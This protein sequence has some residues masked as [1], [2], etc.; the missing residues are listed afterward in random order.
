MPSTLLPFLYQTRTLLR[1]APRARQVVIRSLHTSAGR[2]QPRPPSEFDIPFDNDVDPNIPMEPTRP[3]TI[4][5]TEREAF[6]RIFADIKARGLK[7]KP[8]PVEPASSETAAP[9]S[10]R[11]AMLIMQQ[12][13][14]DAG[15]ARQPSVVSP[16]LLADASADRNKVLLRFP[17]ELRAA[18]SRALET[19]DLHIPGVRTREPGYGD[20][21]QDDPAR[22]DAN[23]EDWESPPHT[24]SRTLELEARRQPERQR[25]EGLISAAENDFDLWQVLEEEVFT[26]P[27]RLGLTGAAKGKPDPQD[28]VNGAEQAETPEP[29]EKLNLYV[30]GPLYPAYLLLALRRLNNAFHSSSPLVF[31]ILPRIKELGVESYV[32]GVSLPFYNDLLDIYWTR[33]G[34]LTGMLGLLE[35]MRQCGLYFDAKTVSILNQADKTAFGLAGEDNR[36]EFGRLIMDMPEYEETQRMR[37]RHWHRAVDTSIKQRQDDIAL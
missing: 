33:R 22:A 23:P 34:D 35:E 2:R 6:E 26:M 14:E 27:A 3:S 7:P 30:H 18:A 32:L 20:A 25:V 1:A 19:V 15:H 5:P 9:S 10:S 29:P 36:S 11:S 4:T 8:N 16:A 13:T 28:G 37:L 17:P 12:A 21:G 31:S 24:Y